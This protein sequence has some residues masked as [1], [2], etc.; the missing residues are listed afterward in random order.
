MIK[1]STFFFLLK[2]TDLPRGGGECNLDLLTLQ[3]E[4]TE[5]E[6]TRNGVNWKGEEVEG[7]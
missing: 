3:S 7:G 4:E 5:K 2:Y 6:G 1:L